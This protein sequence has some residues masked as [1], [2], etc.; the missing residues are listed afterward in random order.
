MVKGNSQEKTYTHQVCACQVMSP[1]KYKTNP[2]RKKKQK[3]VKRKQNKLRHQ[4]SPMVIMVTKGAHG[5]NCEREL[6]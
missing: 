4:Q 1:A 2:K 6:R 3:N 5:M